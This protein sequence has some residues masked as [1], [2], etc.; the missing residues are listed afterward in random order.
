MN[1]TKKIILSSTIGTIFGGVAPLVASVILYKT[2]Q[3]G[4]IGYYLV[5]P[6]M[7]AL[8]C[9]LPLLIKRMTNE[10]FVR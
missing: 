2:G 6:A 4:Y 5:I 7:I 3:V 10:Y 9:L 1:N 8:V